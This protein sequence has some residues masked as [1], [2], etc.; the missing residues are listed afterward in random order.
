MVLHAQVREAKCEHGWLVF[1]YAGAGPRPNCL[2]CPCAREGMNEL[3]CPVHGEHFLRAR[4][5]AECCGPDSLKSF[6]RPC[7]G[8]SRDPSPRTLRSVVVEMPTHTLQCWG[9]I[10]PTLLSA[11][12]DSRAHARELHGPGRWDAASPSFLSPAG[13]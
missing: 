7:D 2:G 10:W 4:L 11:G 5:C 1:P 3:W 6:H 12:T 13:F 8:C 9:W